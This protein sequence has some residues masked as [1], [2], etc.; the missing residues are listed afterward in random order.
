MQLPVHN[1]TGE[2]AENVEVSDDVFGVPLREGVVHQALVMQ[3]ANRRQGTVQTKTRAA[4][5]GSGKKLYAQKHTGRARRGDITSPLLRGGAIAFGPQ[6]REHR[7]DMPKRMRRLALRCVL[8][9]KAADGGL[10]VVSDL[11]LE[12]SKTK[13]LARILKALDISGPV[14]I[15]TSEVEPGV[16]QAARNLPDVSTT[17]AAL[18]NVADVL[19]CRTLLMTVGAVRRAEELWTPHKARRGGAGPAV[20]E[21]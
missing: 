18:L 13:E 14:L 4:V 3:L 16:V 5:S 12:E 20:L 19:S 6:P 2:F 21:S 11:G 17:P 8:S 1:V 7:Q 10:K 15:A 9:G